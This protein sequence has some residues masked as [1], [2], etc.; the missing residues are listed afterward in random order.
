MAEPDRRAT[1]AQE[2]GQQTVQSPERPET[3][4]RRTSSSSVGVRSESG[5]Q[6]MDNGQGSIR[7]DPSR[8]RPRP[9]RL[10]YGTHQTAVENRMLLLT[11]YIQ[12]LYAQSPPDPRVSYQQM[13][14]RDRQRGYRRRGDRGQADER[15]HRRILTEERS[16]LPTMTPKRWIQTCDWREH[17]PKRSYSESET[18]KQSEIGKTD[19]YGGRR[20]PCGG[21]QRRS[22]LR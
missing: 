16:S 4:T 10:D 15:L 8:N 18:D 21:A 6:D 7:S 13:P 12:V 11:D 22:P 5:R 19:R 2:A 3:G 14:K 1:G 9:Q 20:A 17:G